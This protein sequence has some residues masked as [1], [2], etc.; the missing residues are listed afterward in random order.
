M[1]PFGNTELGEHDPKDLAAVGGN[2]HVDLGANSL[3]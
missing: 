3:R 1:S 2:G